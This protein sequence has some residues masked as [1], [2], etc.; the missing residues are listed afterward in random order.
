[1]FFLLL[2]Y[3]LIKLI[4]FWTF[5]SSEISLKISEGLFSW[6]EGH[7]GSGPAKEECGRDRWFFTAF[8]SSYDNA[9]GLYQALCP[10]LLPN[11][12]AQT[13]RG[14]QALWRRGYRMGTNDLTS[15]IL[16]FPSSNAITAPK[17]THRSFPALSDFVSL[18]L[19]GTS[20]PVLL[21]LYF[22]CSPSCSY[23]TG[24]IKN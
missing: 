2:S 19:N 15:H 18:P 21:G 1:M 7:K 3:L 14:V 23:L 6:R 22:F 10:I 4:W 9:T 5:I 12:R 11:T 24:F 13:R 8:L 17:Q 20:S 16:A